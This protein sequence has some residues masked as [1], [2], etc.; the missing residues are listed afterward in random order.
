MP[1]YPAPAG[2]IIWA[3]PEPQPP[4]RRRLIARSAVVPLARVIAAG[5]AAGWVA[6]AVVFACTF[7]APRAVSG[8]DS[9][10]TVTDLMFGALDSAVVLCLLLMSRTAPGDRP[11]RALRQAARRAHPVR[12]WRPRLSRVLQFFWLTPVAPALPRWARRLL[13]AALWASTVVGFW[14]LADGSSPADP[15]VQGQRADA[16]IWLAHLIVWCVLGCAVLSRRRG[17][18]I[19]WQQLQA[20]RVAGRRA[21]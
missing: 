8:L 7:V 9:V 18:D 15:T 1:R 4:P 3:L 10:R 21:P 2:P 13:A 11:A 12:G 14:Q 6:A 16:A 20:R 19:R 17:S 5:S